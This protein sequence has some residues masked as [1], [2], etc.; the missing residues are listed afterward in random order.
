MSKNYPHLFTPLRIGKVF[1]KSRLFTSPTHQVLQGNERTPTEAVMI[2]YANKAKG[3]A[4][5]IT[6]GGTNVIKDHEVFPFWV[7]YDIHSEFSMRYFAQLADTIHFYGSKVSIEISHGPSASDV[8]E[9][10]EIEMDSIADSYADA[11]VWLKRAGFDML[12]L[13]G[14][15]GQGLEQFVSPL[16]NKRTDKYGGTMENRARFP[17]MVLDRV[18]RKVDRDLLIEYRISGTEYTPGGLEINDCIE[19][20]RLIEDKIDLIHVSAGNVFNIST[21]AVMHP[22]GFMPPAPNAYL[23]EAVKKSGVKV[24]V[25]TVGSIDDPDLAERLLAEG[26][27]DVIAMARGILADPEFGNKAREGRPED[28]VPC[29]KCF[30][31]LD[32]HKNNNYFTCSVN[33]SIGRE[34]RLPLMI[35]PVG[36][37]KKIVVVGGGPAGMEAAV[38]AAGRGHDVTL[39]EKK[40]VLGGQLNFADHV[41]F[42][43]SMKNF[44]E[45]LISQVKKSGINLKLER[46][47]TPELLKTEDADIVIVAI[48]AESILPPIPGLDRESVFLAPKVFG[49]TEQIGKRVAIIGGGQVGCETGL[50]L[51]DLGHEVVIVEMQDTIAPDAPFT[52]RIPLVEKMDEGLKYITDARCTKITDKGI[53]FVDKEGIEKGI[54]A[55][56]VVVAAGMKARI[57]EA[58]R[59]FESAPEVIAAGDCIEAKNVKFAVRTAFNAAVRL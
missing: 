20:V 1:F 36:Q 8:N 38:V 41:S 23:A 56:T 40:P 10:D 11:A 18:R 47:V 43:Y 37:K 17:L 6:L 31:C 4:A 3:G 2:H 22:S 46:S 53:T 16:F 39:Y 12:L 13:H 21:R 50:Y 49:N 29:I 52:Y 42:K 24:P 35:P 54:D 48:G 45:Y 27:A 14:G 33:P 5:V 7:D 19:F 34:H 25:V 15:H 59:F 51:A 9:M 55:E 30:N 32:D 26:K 57:A 44:K 28:I 58:D